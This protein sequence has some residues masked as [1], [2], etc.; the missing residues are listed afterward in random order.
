[1]RNRELK[2][3]FE[4]SASLL[5]HSSYH[6]MTQRFLEILRGLK[7]V[8]S[9]AS[10]EIFGDVAKRTAEINHHHDFLVRRFP[11][12]LE[13]ASRDEHYETLQKVLDSHR[14][15]IHYLVERSGP[16]MSLDVSR[17]VKPRRVVLLKGKLNGFNVALVNGLFAVY[18]NQVALLDKKERDK[19]SSLPNRHSFDLI[20]SQVL[21]FYR[22]SKTLP[23]KCSWLAMLDIDHFKQINDSRG[24]LYGDEVLLQFARLFEQTFRYSDFLFRFGG[25][26]FVVILNQTNLEGA[27]LSLERFRRRVEGHCFPGGQVTVSVGFT[28]VEPQKAAARLVEEADRALYRSKALGRNKLTLYSAELDQSKFE[29]DN[30]E[31]F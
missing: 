26:E 20:L 11:N 18:A 15:G 30:A 6:T 9:V 23:P 25:D 1:M 17:D 22:R 31:L 4:L 12:S 19:L 16:W 21:D 29:L 14:G 27:K 5:E 8:E 13:E 7:G 3:A 24:H 10:Y 2:L 28:V